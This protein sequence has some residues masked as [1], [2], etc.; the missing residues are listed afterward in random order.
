[1][2]DPSKIP[3][4]KYT[5]TEEDTTNSTKIIQYSKEGWMH[6]NFGA[7]IITLLGA[8]IIN[9][10]FGYRERIISDE[11]NRVVAGTV[12]ILVKQVRTLEDFMNRDGRVTKETYITTE[13][14]NYREWNKRFSKLESI[15]NL[16]KYQINY[17]NK[18][19]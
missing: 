7:L 1:M 14:N 15:V 12:T 6:K 18:E 5:R 16:L 8:L 4:K 19:K 3:S 13:S 2:E 9:S 17:R 11:R 10:A